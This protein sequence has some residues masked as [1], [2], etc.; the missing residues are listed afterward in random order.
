VHGNDGPIFRR[1]HLKD[2]HE[3]QPN[4]V[5]GN[6][7]E[8]RVERRHLTHGA[9]SELGAIEALARIVDGTVEIHVKGA[10]RWIDAML[11]QLA[12]KY[13]QANDGK[14]E[15]QNH[16]KEKGIHQVWTSLEQCLNL[17]PQG[18]NK[19]YEPECSQDAKSSN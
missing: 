1:H 10:R 17:Q 9:I 11:K 18:R 16:E 2:G 3:R 19:L 13:L 7:V 4:V 15:K 12:T 6:L 14:D 5:K 8:A